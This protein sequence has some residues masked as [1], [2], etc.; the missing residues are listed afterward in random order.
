MAVQILTKKKITKFDVNDPNYK[1][2]PKP[3]HEEINGNLKEDED[4]Y[5]EKKHTYLHLLLLKDYH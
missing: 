3:E 4:L 5:G 2:L 1:P